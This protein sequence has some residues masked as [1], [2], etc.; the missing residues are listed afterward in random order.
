M[1][2]FGGGL[3]GKKSTVFFYEQPSWPPRK[4]AAKPSSSSIA[5]ALGGVGR[6]T[7][8]TANEYLRLAATE[9]SGQGRSAYSVQLVLVSGPGMGDFIARQEGARRVAITL[10]QMYACLAQAVQCTQS[11]RDWCLSCPWALSKVLAQAPSQ[12]QQFLAGCATELRRRPLRAPPS[13]GAPS[14]LDWP[15]AG[16]RWLLTAL[17]GET[18]A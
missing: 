5:A 12:S 3:E 16:Q 8:A 11:C 10:P 7:Y 6:S 9:S 1:P 17:R 4:L 2:L 15:C 18:L 14:I 13:N